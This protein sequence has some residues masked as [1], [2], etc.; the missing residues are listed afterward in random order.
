M[1]CKLVQAAYGIDAG[2]V[3]RKRLG[4]EGL[5]GRFVHDALV[6]AP[7][8]GCRIAC[9]G[10]DECPELV[11][12]PV[13]NLA[14]SADAGLVGGDLGSREIFAVGVFEEVV[15]RVCGWVAGR[16]VE[17]PGAIVAAACGEADHRNGGRHCCRER[18]C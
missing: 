12:G 3:C 5:N 17:T 4:I 9:A 6:H 2:Q 7:H 8:L 1:D 11:L 13:E 14:A 16:E 15:S 10:V 18:E